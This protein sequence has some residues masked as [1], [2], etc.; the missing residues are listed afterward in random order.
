MSVQQKRK[1]N[2]YVLRVIRKVTNK[3]IEERNEREDKELG[4]GRKR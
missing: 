2:E 3:G 4:K 1:E